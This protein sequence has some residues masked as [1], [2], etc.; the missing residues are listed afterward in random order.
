MSQS[1]RLLLVRHPGTAATRAARVPQDEPPIGRLPDLAPWL[2]RGG[3]V[4]TSPARRAAVPGAP[5]ERL[6]GPW[7]LGCWAGRPLAELEDIGRWRADP[8]YDGHGGESLLAL[9]DRAGALLEQ[10]HDE[11]GRLAAVT[12]GAVVR[13]VLVSVLQAPPAAFWSLDVAPGGV[14]EVHGRAPG[15]RVTR[16]NAALEPVP[17]DP[18]ATAGPGT[19]AG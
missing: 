7:D 16:V 19:G 8:S 18:R 12:H 15:W 10:W 13:A 2:G 11:R 1:R 6:L 4:V 5:V 14:T 3:T 9:L 17:G